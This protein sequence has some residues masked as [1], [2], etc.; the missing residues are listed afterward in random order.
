MNGKDIL[1]FATGLAVGSAITWFCVK[2][3]YRKIANNEI[4]EIREYYVNKYARDEECELPKEWEGI[5]T[6]SERESDREQ[7][8]K[9]VGSY[10]EVKGEI[11]PAAKSQIEVISPDEFGD[12]EGYKIT[13]IVCFDDNVFED[14][15]FNII[16]RDEFDDVIGLEVLDELGMYEDDSVYIRNDEIKTYFEVIRDYR[17]Y[18]DARK[19]RSSS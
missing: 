6:V 10:A 18:D 9:E 4:D 14:D 19:C 8:L 13:T 17:S 15:E 5:V 12:L 2:E 11:E 3:R 7:Y 1:V 16:S